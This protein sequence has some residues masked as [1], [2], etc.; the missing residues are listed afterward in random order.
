MNDLEDSDSYA[1]FMTQWRTYQKVIDENYMVH[2]ELYGAASHWICKDLGPSPVML[3]LGCG[4][5]SAA[6]ILLES[7]P[8][9]R[10]IGVDGALLA[11]EMGRR[12]LGLLGN[13]LELHHADMR[14]YLRG[15][16]PR[17]ADVILV[18][19]ALHHLTD[20]EKKS[21]LHLCRKILTRNGLLIVID[22]FRQDGESRTDCLESLCEKVRSDWAALDDS[23]KNT[24]IEHIRNHDYPSEVGAF[25]ETA[26]AE[27]LEKRHACSAGGF[28]T[29]FALG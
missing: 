22:L 2:R 1:F 23:E 12:T 7:R 4:D 19:F 20:T 9:S 26:H 21:F 15:A 14:D 10:Y 25:L 27:G 8:F 17:S 29:A 6:K 18:S 28:Y 24:I 13:K 16:A 3:D 11:L 5:G